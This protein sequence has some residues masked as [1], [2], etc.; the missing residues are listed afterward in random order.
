MLARGRREHVDSSAVRRPFTA[1]AAHGPGCH[2]RREADE[3][4]VLHVFNAC[5]I[6]AH[7]QG[8][9]VLRIEGDPDNPQNHGQLCLKG[10]AGLYGLDNPHRI[11]TPLRRTNPEKGIGVDPRWEPLPWEE[12]LTRSSPIVSR[13]FAR[14]IPAS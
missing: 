7:T 10:R 11:T 6:V 2:R 13:R 5:G 12:A 14:M 8:N 4:H 1:G 3:V 9:R